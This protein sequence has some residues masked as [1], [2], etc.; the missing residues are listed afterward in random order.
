MYSRKYNSTANKSHFKIISHK[1]QKHMYRDCALYSSEY[2]D[3]ISMGALS[4]FGYHFNWR[5]DPCHVTENNVGVK[6]KTFE[7]PYLILLLVGMFVFFC[8][9]FIQ[10]C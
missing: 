1:H 4:I 5:Q 8:K 6:K 9:D 7:F 3:I 10:L 2:L